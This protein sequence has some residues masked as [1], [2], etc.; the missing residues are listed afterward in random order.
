MQSTV[1]EMMLNPG[2]YNSLQHFGQN[3]QIRHWPIVFHYVLVKYWLLQQ[4]SDMSTLE[5]CRHTKEAL[6]I[7]VIIG[8][9]SKTHF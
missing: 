7:A 1:Y 3:G 6:V 2:V 4:W 9:C 5:I 8:S